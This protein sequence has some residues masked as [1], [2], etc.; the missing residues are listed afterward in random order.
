M[1]A[2]ELATRIGHK[3]RLRPGTNLTEV[4][5]PVCQPDGPKSRGSS[6]HAIVWDEDG[7]AHIK[8]T[9]K[10]CPEADILSLLNLTQDDR[11]HDAKP[12][13]QTVVAVAEPVGP[14]WVQYRVEKVA[15]RYDYQ[16][17]DG[18]YTLSK[19]RFQKPDGAKDF[20]SLV[21][22]GDKCCWSLAHLNGSANLIY[23]LPAVF[24]AIAS[25]DT[26]YI[27]EGEKACDRMKE[28]GLV[29][30]CQRSGAG[31]GKWLPQHTAWLSGAKQVVIVADRD[32]AGESYAREVCELLR[33]AKIRARVVQSKTDKAKD[34]AYDHL[35]AGYGAGDFIARPDLEPVRGLASA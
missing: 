11:R 20:R 34:D 19:I 9:I 16:K 23:N 22:D 24:A 3:S 27:N 5:C 13:P 14:T 1:Y 15:K 25:G 2:H 12:K 31:P 30:T 26:I 7:W 32:E 18:T 35:E 10:N 28:A 8:C 6:G 33:D 4:Y 17:A 29:G 21:I